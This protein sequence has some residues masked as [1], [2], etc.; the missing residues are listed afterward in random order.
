MTTPDTLIDKV[1]N[2]LDSNRMLESADRIVCAVSGGPDSIFLANVLDQLRDDLNFG[3]TLAHVNY[4]T[5]GADSDLDE[6]LCRRFA[7][8]RNLKIYVKSATE[9][10]LDRIRSSNFQREA[11]ALRMEFLD[12]V[13][14]ETGAGSIAVGH[15]ADD[16][17]ETVLMH[18]LRGSG[19]AGIS[20]IS[21]VSGHTVR[22]IIDC[23]KQDIIEFLDSNG[24]EYRIDKSNL[25]ND[26]V[27]NQVRNLLIPTIRD[28]FNPRFSEAVLRLSRIARFTNQF[29][30]ERVRRL[31]DICLSWSRMGKI[32]IDVESLSNAPRVLQFGLIRRAYAA[33][34]P[35]VRHGRSLD[36]ELV[37][38]ILGLFSA[39]NGKCLDLVNNV[40]VEK[41][42]KTLVM[43]LRDCPAPRESRIEVPG[44]NPLDQFCL[45]LWTEIVDYDG[46]EVKRT[47]E[48]YVM[49]DADCSKGDLEV[50]PIRQGDR[51][52]LLNSPGT[53]KVSD[54]LTDRKIPK[55]LRSEIPVLVN[56]DGIIWIPGIGIAHRV[57]IA[58]STSKALKLHAIPYVIHKDRR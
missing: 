10:E 24:I 25:G 20:G 42:V 54:I 58:G 9:S 56:D 43:Y 13:R 37:E 11:R 31:A 21:P 5:R 33:L 32:L 12:R 44:H 8:G 26:Y 53:R 45:E 51:V 6:Q 49:V 48:W 46:E 18:F 17:V 57:R 15:T 29:I 36:Q 41:G 30:E 27:R 19:L 39:D 47:D 2:T 40:V 35:G 52:R 34:M 16:V 28:N 4:H 14:V 22:P 50:R 3:L 7:D 23:W 55:A 38:A 1:K